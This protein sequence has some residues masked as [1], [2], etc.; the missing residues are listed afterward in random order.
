VEERR[1]NKSS[2]IGVSIERDVRGEWQIAIYT[3]VFEESSTVYVQ[4]HEID[5]LIEWLQEA[6]KQLDEIKNEKPEA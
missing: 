6:A 2:Q 3:P 5:L 4:L 1:F